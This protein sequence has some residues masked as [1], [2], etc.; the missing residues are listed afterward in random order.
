MD[1]EIKKQLVALLYQ[2]RI[3]TRVPP[4]GGRGQDPVCAAR[5]VQGLGLVG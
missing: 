5:Q 3:A 2:M 1:F 4:L